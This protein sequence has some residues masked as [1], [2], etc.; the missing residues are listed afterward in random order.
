MS[1]NK[2]RLEPVAKHKIQMSVP[3]HVVENRDTTVEVWSNDKKLGRVEISKGSIDWW[4]AGTSTNYRHVTWEKFAEI[5]EA[6]GA[7]RKK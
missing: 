3:G 1:L 7:P 5:M 4:P 6:H 2:E